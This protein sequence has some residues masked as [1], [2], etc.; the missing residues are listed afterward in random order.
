VDKV[1]VKEA[2]SRVHDYWRPATVAELNGQEVRL[3]RFR[4]EFPWHRHEH[5]DELFLGVRGTFRL[6][7]RDRAIEI[8]PGELVVVPRGTEH[9]PVADEEVEV[10]LF[11]PATTRNTGN[12][13]DE[14]F[15]APGPKLGDDDDRARPSRR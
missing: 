15:T 2:F 1:N 9:R 10:L 12:V 6:E 8:G 5:E 13:V 7:L 3:V 4:G 14:T 11:E